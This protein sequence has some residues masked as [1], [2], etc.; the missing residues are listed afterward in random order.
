MRL[1]SHPL[2]RM[3][4]CLLWLLPLLVVQLLFMQFD[5]VGTLGWYAVTSVLVVLAFPDLFTSV[6]FGISV[7][8]SLFIY[9][10]IGSA[11]VPI[12]FAIWEPA[13]W[14][15]LREIR[16]LEMTEFEWFHWWPFKTIVTILCL[17][18]ATVT[19]LRIPLTILSVGVWSI[20]S[21]VIMMVLGSVVY[22]SNKV[23]G[24]VLISRCRVV[25][26]AQNQEPVSMVVTPNNSI[27]VGDTSYSISNINPYWELKSGDDAGQVAYAVSISVQN[28]T[29]SFT[30]QMIVGYP[31]YTEDMIRTDD[32]AQPMSRAI[33]AIGRALVDESLIMHLEPDEKDR[34]YITQ[35]GALYIRELSTQGI[36]LSPWTERAIE[37]L[38]RFNDYIADGEDVWLP[39]DSTPK[40]HPLSLGVPPTSEDDPIDQ[41]M[42]I[43]SYL[44]YAYM[45]SRVVAG[46]ETLFPVAWITL[47]RN[48]ATTQS[49]QLFAFDQ[50]LNTAD[51]S[52]MSFEWVGSDVERLEIEQSMV[53]K[54]EATIHGSQYELVLTN[55]QEYSQIGDTDYSYRVKSIQNNLNIGGN[56]ISLAEIDIQHGEASWTRWV[57]DNS[58][59]NRDVTEDISHDSAKFLDSNITMKYEPGGAPITI[60]GGQSDGSLVILT[61]LAGERPTSKSTE[62]GSPVLLT[63]NISIT[64]DR[65][66][67]YT[68]R[69]TR[70]AI[71][72]R[73]QR[74]P[75]ASNSFSMVLVDIQNEAGASSAW[76]QYHPYP[77]RSQTDVVR[78]F[79]YRPT[80]LML[81]N[82]RI[83]EIIFSRRSHALPSP[84][85]LDR[86]EVDS[87]LG[88]F[89]GRTSS[90]LNWRSVV[91]FLDGTDKPMAISVN[92]PKQYQDYWFFQSQWD[93][94][95]ATSAGL[96][97][98]VLGIGNR[99]GVLV[100]LLGC[101]L[102]VS[103][104][105][106]AF[107]VKPMIKRR[108][109]Q[110]REVAA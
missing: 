67:P 34:F 51:S 20:H 69:I 22:F 87:H 26:E 68:R 2:F 96:N 92:D 110:N 24:D 11:G 62:I 99:H 47:H 70:P 100:M 19:L 46:G 48:D 44:R 105:I 104:M 88:G 16:G 74:D 32:P 25:I 76:L 43:R 1:P 107:F 75:A 30:R 3:P 84:V 14:V 8:A 42:T 60:V 94:P 78:R 83:V 86:F 108:R 31:E 9:S 37:N 56:Q 72:P 4:A 36:P 39:G 73:F 82:K 21:G 23:E 63:E 7:L 95:D 5:I 97:Y 52:I 33:K 6:W 79:E 17:N 66:E 53:P 71:V 64:L 77:F 59:L 55:T 65:I 45:D 18:M 49:I 40:L 35:S 50:K 90:I 81:R 106:W 102:A 57:F 29:G 54:L 58:K 103:G 28:P 98:T 61:S 41:D 80:T 12:S 13:T 89:S 101:C 109:Q 15:N 38:P 27:V 10:S 85:I 91:K 93:P